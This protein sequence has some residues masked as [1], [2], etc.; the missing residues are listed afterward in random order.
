LLNTGLSNSPF[1]SPEGSNPF[2]PFK[3]KILQLP[4]GLAEKKTT[5]APEKAFNEGGSQKHVMTNWH[6]IMPEDIRGC[7]N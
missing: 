1:Q 4:N 5:D 3:P 7:K 2:E 6:F